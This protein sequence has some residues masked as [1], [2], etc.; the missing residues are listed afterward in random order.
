MTY[1][2]AQLEAAT[3]FLHPDDMPSAMFAAF[4]DEP[5]LAVGHEVRYAGMTGI[6]AAVFEPSDHRDDVM[7]M[8]S[9]VDGDL[10]CYDGAMLEEDGRGRWELL[11]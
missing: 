9:W 10:D 1:A 3:E 5:E 2:T 8:V 7:V 6:I 11:D 4:D